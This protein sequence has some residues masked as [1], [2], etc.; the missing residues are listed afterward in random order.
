MYTVT[1]FL[2][3]LALVLQPP[4]PVARSIGIGLVAALP[5]T[6]ML[7]LTGFAG[8]LPI[9]ISI[10]TLLGIASIMLAVSSLSYIQSAPFRVLIMSSIVAMP[11][12]AA[13]LYVL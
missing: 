12:C 7:L 2:A 11:G 10:G 3:G 13:L 6:V 8:E 5:L 4:I 1:S 9:V